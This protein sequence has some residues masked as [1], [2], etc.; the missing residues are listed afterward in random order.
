VNGSDIWNLDGLYFGE[1]FWKVIMNERASQ[2]PLLDRRDVLP[3]RTKNAFYWR[4]WM[5]CTEASHS[6]DD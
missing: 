4:G 3:C 5:C 2:L 6:I 1:H